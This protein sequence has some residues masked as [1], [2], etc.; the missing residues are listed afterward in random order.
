MPDEVQ[1]YSEPVDYGAIQQDVQTVTDAQTDQIGS[2][3]DSAVAQIDESIAEYETSTQET[4][5]QLAESVARD[6]VSEYVQQT[7]ETQTQDN[8]TT[9]MVTLSADQYGEIHALLTA[10]FYASIL[11]VVLLS[12]LMGVLLWQIAVRGR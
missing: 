3:L 4:V 11:T 2:R 5:S 7:G 10:S 9:N 6:T 12:A 1:T 8:G